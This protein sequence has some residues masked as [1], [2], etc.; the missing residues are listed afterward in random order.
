MKTIY[1]LLKS[2]APEG[3]GYFDGNDMT[4]LPGAEIN[5]ICE[6]RI[7][8]KE[9][10]ILVIGDA[11]FHHFII[12][13][14]NS[15]KDKQLSQSF[16]LEE[17]A[18]RLS[19]LIETAVGEEFKVEDRF[20]PHNPQKRFFR[21]EKLK[22]YEMKP[23]EDDA[24]TSE[25]ILNLLGSD[26]CY[27]FRREENLSDTML[28]GL[29]KLGI[30]GSSASQENNFEA[31]K[32]WVVYENNRAYEDHTNLK[33][34]KVLEEKNFFCEMGKAIRNFQNNDFPETVLWHPKKY[35][36]QKEDT[37]FG[38]LLFGSNDES[39]ERL[40]KK[41]TVFL[42][43]TLQ[44]VYRFG[45]RIDLSIEECLDGVIEDFNKKN[46]TLKQ[47]LL[48]KEIVINCGID[49]AF[50]IK[51]KDGVNSREP[52]LA[53]CEITVI[54]RPERTTTFYRS[55]IAGDMDGYELLM[56]TSYMKCRNC[57]SLSSSSRDGQ[58][59]SNHQKA[60]ITAIKDGLFRMFLQFHLGYL[61][62]YGKDNSGTKYKTVCQEIY[63]I[64]YNAQ[65]FPEVQS[66]Q[67]NNIR[68][69]PLTH[70]SVL[71]RAYYDVTKKQCED[72][73][74]PWL[75]EQQL[76]E[77]NTKQ[78]GPEFLNS[79]VRKGLKN[80]IKSKDDDMKIK[81]PIATFGNMKV[82]DVDEITTLR[83]LHSLMRKYRI[84]PD[85]K[86][87]GLAVFGAPGDGKSR[88]VIEVAKSVFGITKEEHLKDIECNL[89]QFDKPDDL[90][91][92]LLKARDL[93]KGNS[94]PL[95][96][97]DEFDSK[98]SGT[99]FGWFKYLLPLLQDG[100]FLYNGNLYD[101]PKS[102]VICAGGLNRSFLEFGLRSNEQKF[103]DAKGPDLISRLRGY[104]NMKGPNPYSPFSQQY[105][106]DES[107]TQKVHSGNDKDFT[108]Y[109]DAKR[110]NLRKIDE[111][112][113]GL[114][115]IRRAVLIRSVLE[116]HM[117]S[118]I[119]EDDEASIE[120]PVLSALLNV[121][122]YN[123]GIRSIQAIIEMSVPGIKNPRRFTKGMIPLM[124]QLEIHVDA[125]EFYRLLNE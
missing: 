78:K 55:E 49:F 120:D 116:R 35:E 91:Q 68:S 30:T 104:V 58:D 82:V 111:H 83:S 87:L 118:I 79:I 85:T 69:A 16:L 88:S 96:F 75:L 12:P 6:Q 77:L 39:A 29:D 63:K 64:A 33:H 18:A 73:I 102:I 117:K 41:T 122:Q 90:S 92:K 42:S 60:S 7:M 108:D 38:D 99:D 10:K 123:Y 109:Q 25:K 37:S 45:R 46:G 84:S 65:D 103:I 8:P 51:P 119:S 2:W 74:A 76:E 57:Q 98:L 47:F 22:E 11:W 43:M 40:R 67:L 110:S 21:T 93:S 101:L 17:A 48:C 121:P 15:I 59:D 115:K 71:Y 72:F 80:M 14:G 53:D 50:L 114:Y 52:S 89:A 28:V 97:L 32:H 36:Y 124:E 61:I 27:P 107:I 66:V 24:K 86:P 125:V 34:L 94:I 26:S 70:P 106:I 20:I 13:E 23:S 1:G 113:Y 5:P 31:F 62:P 3:K 105:K 81:F 9:N 100:T 4:A 56:L 112:D 95:I 19:H 54:F 44:T